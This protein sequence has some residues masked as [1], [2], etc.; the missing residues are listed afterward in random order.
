MT[1]TFDRHYVDIGEGQVLVFQ[2]GLGAHL[3]QV[4]GLLEGLE[5]VRLICMDCPGHGQSPLAAD[6]EPSFSAYTH[7]VLRLLDHLGIEK[8]VFGG[9]SMGSGIALHT[10]IHHPNRVEGLILVRPAWLDTGTPENLVE[11][12]DIVDFLDQ[13]DGK[14]QFEQIPAFQK[15]KTS[16]PN[17][18]NSILGM[19]N[20]DQQE[21]TPRILTA[22]VNDAPLASLSQLAGVSQQTVVI[23]NEDDPLH[24]LEFARVIDAG[25]PN[26]QLEVVISRYIHD[27]QHREEVRR[28]VSSFLT[29][30]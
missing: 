30:I 26:S 28:I 22:M 25:L 10:A 13:P 23:G 6:Y 27:R 16:L 2:H 3:G 15:I 18:A 5:G 17:A 1:K 12:K 20:R 19:F 29:H 11:L 21:A 9:I 7:D 24:P 14:Q 8:A 4:Q